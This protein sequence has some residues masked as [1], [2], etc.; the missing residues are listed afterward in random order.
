MSSSNTPNDSTPESELRAR[1]A[2]VASEKQA[3]KHT[4]MSSRARVSPCECVQ[5]LCV[6]AVLTVVAGLIVIALVHATWS[7]MTEVTDV[8]A[9]CVYRTHTACANPVGHMSKCNYAPH[10]YCSGDAFGHA[11]GLFFLRCLYA[12]LYAIRGPVMFVRWLGSFL[13]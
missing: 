1:H 7:Y 11:V 6:I 2:R 13:A 4:A 8:Y 5:A 9:N 3:A 10:I 12:G